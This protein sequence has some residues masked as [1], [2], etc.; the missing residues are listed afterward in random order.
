M[1][2]PGLIVQIPVLKR[3]SAPYY[4]SSQFTEAS[5]TMYEE[6][7]TAGREETSFPIVTLQ[8][9]RLADPIAADRTQRW[10]SSFSE[11]VLTS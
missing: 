1:S 8:L 5:P 6:G 7:R 11:N 4:L 10:F 2:V 9:E 3:S